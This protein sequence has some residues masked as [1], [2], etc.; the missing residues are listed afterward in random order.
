VALNDQGST[1]HGAIDLLVQTPGGV[2]VI[3]HKSDQ[4]DD[5]TGRFGTYWPQLKAY[6]DAVRS[7]GAQPVRGVA[8]NW[9][10]AGEAML[11]N[12]G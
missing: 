1:I 12:L 5:R 2:W 10:S 7:D 3:D 9:I 4:T 6:A 8:V 11:M